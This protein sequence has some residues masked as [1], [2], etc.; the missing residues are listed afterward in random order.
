MPRGIGS[1]CPPPSVMTYTV[2]G[3]SLRRACSGGIA[4]A[5]PTA[6]TSIRSRRDAI[7]HWFRRGRRGR[8]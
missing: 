6:G 1:G 4:R 3:A 2:I 5:G 7:P 8:N